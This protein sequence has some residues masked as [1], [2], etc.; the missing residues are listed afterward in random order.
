MS[1]GEHTFENR[2]WV[3]RLPIHLA[4]RIAKL[5]SQT[6]LSGEYVTANE[7]VAVIETMFGYLG[8]LWVA[9]YVHA[10]AKDAAIN[11]DLLN[12]S[13]RRVLTGQWVSLARRI[14]RLFAEQAWSTVVAALGELAFGA[15]DDVQDPVTRLIAY[16][17]S[18]SHGS[19]A[20][21]IEDI[22]AHRQLIEHLLAGIPALWEQPIHCFAGEDGPPR[23]AVRGWPLMTK[24]MDPKEPRY[25]PFIV[26]TDGETHLRIYPLLHVAPTEEGL[27]LRGG[28]SKGR[29]HVL[30]TLF[31]RETLRLWYGRYRR[32][33][34]GHLAFEEVLRARPNAQLPPAAFSGV[35]AALST[36][37]LA[38][39]IVEAHPGCGKADLVAHLERIAPPASRVETASYVVEPGGLSQSGITFARFLL[40]RAE[41]ALGLHEGTLS[42]A[43][44]EFPAGIAK[45]EEHLFV[46]GVMLLVG[47]EDLHHGVAVYQ[48]EALSIADVFAL[49]SG[50]AIR[51]LGTVHP[52]R[53]GRH[54]ACDRRIALPVPEPSAFS[55]DELR[56][57]LS[58]LC[59]PGD[60]LGRRTL[61]AL[62][63]ARRP[64]T[65]FGLCDA[66]EETS[67]A[68]FE[69]AVEQ[70]LWRL[71]PL[72]VV[73]GVGTER[74]WQPLEGLC[75]SWLS[76]GD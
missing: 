1:I 13:G 5:M 11:R 35:R 50:Q 68:I 69:P 42:S 54:L 27:V 58:E 48:R 57:V 64:L 15:Q 40:R 16:R 17:N 18:F 37:R 46:A 33:Q 41:T 9:E 74:R 2:A 30:E 60:A 3:E 53:M 55:L 61:I 14:R 29:Q 21:V 8:R 51:L 67:H 70:T 39:L 10:G 12:L 36:P 56:V 76:L 62:L 72:L 59:P 45:A 71:M 31:E 25:Q 44:G 20:S 19:L 43:D 24:T 47:I 65:L 73:D 23:L 75:L 38:R 22:R 52:G 63:Q 34:Q 4:E 66:I 7:T 6:A 28:E 49:P 32:E 26:G